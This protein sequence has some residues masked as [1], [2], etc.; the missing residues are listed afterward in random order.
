MRKILLS[1]TTV[2][3]DFKKL[4]LWSDSWVPQ[5]RNRVMSVALMDFL[6]N[7]TNLKE[8]VRKSSEPGHGLVQEV[9][10][11]H[12]KIE[13]FCRNLEIYSPL[14]LIRILTEIPSHKAKLRILQM[15]PNDYYNYSSTSDLFLFAQVPYTKVRS[16]VYRK[17]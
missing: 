2:N 3:P 17:N 10:A 1:I 7:S 11:I 15:T 9:D 5:N 6:N 4:I 8:I 14:S 16:L 13:K 12:S